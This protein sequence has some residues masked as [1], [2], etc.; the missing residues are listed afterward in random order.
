MNHHS[1][2]KAI[3]GRLTNAVAMRSTERDVGEWVAVDAILQGESLWIE[4][5]GVREVGRISVQNAAQNENV[6]SSRE[7]DAFQNSL[8]LQFATN[9]RHRRV[10]AH[11]FLDHA[12]HVSHLVVL[13]QAHF[14]LHL[15]GVV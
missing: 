4:S 1:E 14:L 12:F 10:Q 13:A 11:G 5:I 8:C 2:L 6:S 15:F 9:Y 3:P 7:F